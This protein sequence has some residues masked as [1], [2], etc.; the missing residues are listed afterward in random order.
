MLL[1]R[2]R[3]L[4]LAKKVDYICRQQPHG[5]S[6]YGL[7]I[8]DTGIHIERGIFSITVRQNGTIVLRV[9]DGVIPSSVEEFQPGDWE[10]HIDTAYK[11]AKRHK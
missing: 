1:Q 11:Y 10:H 2:L 9:F 5:F 3:A 7:K 8:T 6:P 4:K